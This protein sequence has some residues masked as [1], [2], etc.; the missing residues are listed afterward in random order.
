MRRVEGLGPRADGE[1]ALKPWCA[2]AKSLFANIV[3]TTRGS[4]EEVN[5][6]KASHCGGADNDFNSTGARDARARDGGFN[7]AVAYTV[8]IAL[9]FFFVICHKAAQNNAGTELRAGL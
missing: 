8:K 4:L 7:K 6:G 1:F 5:V 9:V 3:S 2:R